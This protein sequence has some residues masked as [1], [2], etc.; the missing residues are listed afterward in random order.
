MDVVP[1]TPEQRDAEVKKRIAEARENKSPSLNLS[2]LGLTEIP[3]AI[4]ELSWLT[5]L[6]LGPHDSISQK[7]YW[8]YTEKDKKLCN[9]VRNVPKALTS[10]FPN[11]I[12]LNLSSTQVSDISALQGLTVS[13]QLSSDLF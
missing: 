9:A 5:H 1:Y 7:P 11:L 13:A 12:Q 2:G 6:D 10:A 8:G 4:Y 3:E